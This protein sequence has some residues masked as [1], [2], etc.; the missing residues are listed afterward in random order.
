MAPTKQ[1]LV[2][3]YEANTRRVEGIAARLK[4]Q[5]LSKTVYAG[6]S[7]RDILCHLASTSGSAAYFIGMAQSGGQG[8]GSA[9]DIDKWNLE[10][11]TARRGKSL[12]DVLQEFRTGHD[13][14]TK[15]VEGASDELMAKQVPNFE[16]GMSS[17]ADLIQGASTGHE[18]GHLDDVERA[19][20]A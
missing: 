5:D 9:F 20:G 13:A 11:V 7:V 10:Q 19:L 17:L 14:G 3:A 8:V 18:A 16:G 1:Q 2:E 15:A 6:W 4:E 12:G